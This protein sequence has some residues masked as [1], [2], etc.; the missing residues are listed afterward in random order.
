MY[1]AGRALF[2]AEQSSDGSI[3]GVVLFIG[4]DYRHDTISLVK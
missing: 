3:L 2:S 4:P 1:V